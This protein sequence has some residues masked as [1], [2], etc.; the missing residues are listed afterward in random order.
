[1]YENSNQFE[2]VIQEIW[3]VNN[4]LVL[5][6]SDIF[7]KGLSSP[8]FIQLKNKLML[9]YMLISLRGD[10]NI[11]DDTC[12]TQPVDT[13]NTVKIVAAAELN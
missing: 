5:I 8:R 13:H 1:M 3:K 9:T 2:S 10:V 7:T 6:M 12:T 11:T 4:I